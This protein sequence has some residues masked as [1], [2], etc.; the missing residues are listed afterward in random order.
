MHVSFVR[1]GLL[2][3]ILASLLLPGPGVAAAP[4][5]GDGFASV[6]APPADAATAQSWVQNGA[7]AAPQIVNLEASLQAAHASALA[8]A[9]AA[10]RASSPAAAADN[11]AVAAAV[12][13]YRAYAAA[14]SDANSP[15]AMLGGRVKWLAGRF[16]GLKKR[17]AG[18]DRAAEVRDQELAAYRALFSDWQAQ[19][20][21]IVIRA[22]GELAA[23]GDPAAIASPASRA[24]VQRYRAAMVNEAEV[25]LGL[26][27]FAVERAAGL[28]TAEPASVEPSANTLWDLMSDPRK[29][30]PG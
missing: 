25:L 2:L 22:Q 21:S 10:T 12:E 14:N 30:P 20:T 24:A 9:A 28:A 19:R 6:P 15:A 29:R 23:A 18:T 5:I 3:T 7:V 17:V 4:P 26:T 11:A 16:T 13:G 8:D 27:R 1:P